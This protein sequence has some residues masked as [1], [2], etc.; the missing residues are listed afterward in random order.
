M[1]IKA[2]LILLVLIMVTPA[3]AQ[4]PVIPTVPADILDRIGGVADQV[5]TLP[6]QINED[7]EL[8]DSADPEVLFGYVKYLFSF[9]VAQELLGARLAWLGLALFHFLMINIPLLT[10]YFVVN[11]ITIT[12]KFLKWIVSMIIKLI[13]MIPFF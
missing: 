2:A 9:T 7:V 13:E 6:D 5:N 8:P 1:W 4:G 3:A 10:I 12:I 11:L